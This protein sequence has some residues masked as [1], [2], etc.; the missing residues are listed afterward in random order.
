MLTGKARG[1]IALATIVVTLI[2]LVAVAVLLE[3]RHNL[4]DSPFSLTN[5]GRPVP[6]D[7]DRHQ[8]LAVAQEF[9]LRVDAVNG[10]DPT[11]YVKSV[12]ELLTTKLQGTFASEFQQTQ[13]LGIQAGL[14]GSGN[15]LASGI[16]NMDPDSAT[17]LVA[18][19][20][21]VKDSS[22]T[23]QRHYRW[24]VSL[25]KVDGRWLVDDFTPVT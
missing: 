17:V 11:G 4:T 22:G 10:S 2:A 19:D 14:T 18:H 12:S 8:V 20:A 21:T 9:C 7:S 6:S 25:R 16:A 24:T 5:S 1:W 23:S 15:V 3:R 13:K